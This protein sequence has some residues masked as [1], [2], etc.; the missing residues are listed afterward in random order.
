MLL[1]TGEQ[2]PVRVLP[3]QVWQLLV[4]RLEAL[5]VSLDGMGNGTL[6]AIGREKEVGSSQIAD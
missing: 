2:L 1:S 6:Q 5:S 3:A 4:V